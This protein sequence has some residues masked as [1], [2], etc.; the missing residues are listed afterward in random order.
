MP[1]TASPTSARDYYEVLGVA[2][3][4]SQEAIRDAFRT[5]ALQ[6]HPD[7]NKAPEAQERFREIAQAY[8]VLSDPRKRAEYDAGGFAGVTQEDLF[9]GADFESFLRDAGLGLGESLFDRLFGTRARG[10]VRG[11]DVRVEARVPLERIALGGEETIRFGRRDVC[12]DCHGTGAKAGTQPRTCTAC[13][14]SGRK[15]VEHQERGVR[16]RETGPCPE[17]KGAGRFIETPCP[18]CGGS[19][20]AWREE[21]L[22]VRIPVGAEDGLVLRVPGKGE[23]SPDPHGLPG[24]LLLV[25]ST[26]EDPRFERDGADLWHTEEIEAPEAV[27]G[28]EINVP[29]LDGSV[30]VKVPAGTQPDAQLRLRGKGL[31]RRGGRGHGDLYVRLA[32]RLPKRISSEERSLWTRL[33]EIRRIAAAP[34]RTE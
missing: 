6:F 26:N 15:V 29:T 25:V 28:A 12:G 34:R 4:A 27:L 22:V 10:P 31:P 5:L 8:A 19:G 14:G 3:D 18:V 17:C 7:R 24:D 13:A 33:G 2:R 21:S 20:E 30:A 16:L 1:S 32:V 23:K 11:A 9:A